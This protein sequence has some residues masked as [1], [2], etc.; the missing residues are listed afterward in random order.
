MMGGGTAPQGSRRPTVCHVLHSLSVGGGEVLAHAIAL[1]NRREYRP[2]FALL[3]E[4]GSLG[5]E[6]QNQGFQVEVVERRPGFDLGCARRLARFLRSENVLLIHAHQYGPLLY[7]GLARW[8]ARNP[9][10]LFTEHGRDYPDFRRSRRVWANRLLLGRGDRFVAV[11]EFVARALVD[12][13]G[14]PAERVEV[15]RN[16]RDL[17]AYKA[18]PGLR[19]AIRSELGLSDEDFLILQVARLDPLKDHSTALRALSLMTKQNPAVKLAFVGDGEERSRLEE[20]VRSLGLSESVL[21]LGFRGDVP[22]LLQAGDAFL[23]SS[24]SEGTPLTLIEAMGTGLACV[25]TIVGGVPELI[26]DG[27]D[28]LLAPVGDAA[29]LADRLSRIASDPE[30]RRRLSDSARRHV[31]EDHGA[32]EMHQQYR[33]LYRE[34]TSEVTVAGVEN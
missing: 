25:A 16:G 32:G 13:E 10:I 20:L 21:F 24:I 17:T 11:A 2:V 12:F 33:Q 34:M 4:M 26:R 8:P 6:V 3:D 1:E 7:S 9:P 31:L 27:E 28:G 30:L 29:G 5:R 14:L 23:L 18:K 19:A 22:R 15:I